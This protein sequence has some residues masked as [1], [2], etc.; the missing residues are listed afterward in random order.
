M[1]K[2]VNLTRLKVH[3]S[4][5]RWISNTVGHGPGSVNKRERTGTPGG[6]LQPVDKF[7]GLLGKNELKKKM[8]ALIEG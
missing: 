2:A 4:P 1:D 8:D 6:A 7:T 3:Q 5:G